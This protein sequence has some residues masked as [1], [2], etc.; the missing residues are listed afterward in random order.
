[1]GTAKQSGLPR[2]FGQQ[3]PAIGP[4]GRGL[5]GLAT[6]ASA[7]T[8]PRVVFVDHVARLS[9]AEIAL[10]RLVPALADRVD[11]HV[12]LGEDGPLV[13]R[14]RDAGASVE[15]LPMDGRLRDVRKETVRPGLAQV[16]SLARMLRYVLALRRRL[17]QVRP[18]LVHTNSLKAA[19]YGGIAGRL[20]GIPVIWHVRD[21]IADDY[22]PRS[23]VKAV[24]VLARFLPTAVIAN[25]AATLGT[26]PSVRQSAVLYNP[27]VPDI[28]VSAAARWG[29][30]EVKTRGLV[31]VVGRLAEW[32]GQHVF[33]EAFAKAFAAEPRARGRLIGSAMFGEEE[34]EGRLRALA[35]DLGIAER[36]EF[37]GF[38]ED[39]AAE[40]A[41][42]DILVH[43]SITPE[44]FG[45]V[46]IE[47]M[48]AGVPVIAAAAGGPAEIIL[49]GKDGLLTAPGDVEA[50]AEALQ[51]LAYDRDFR[52][53]LSKAALE[54]VKR[55]SPEAAASQLLGIYT[56]V[57]ARRDPWAL[58]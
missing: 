36:I 33:L 44:P 50:L 39:V 35:K 19:I 40:L 12:I 51:R 6:V 46:V 18:D 38:R 53:A 20:A 9:G 25:S 3:A 55:F 43:C 22:L 17:R 28:V 30:G 34:Y 24:R 45:Q 42:L 14:L 23:A 2:T 58:R 41:E 26:V 10:A 4:A 52:R 57:L 8:R 5:A 37:R 31:G 15:V 32:K 49:N 29:D 13:G 7:V 48:A 27:V 16:A 11:C 1:L 21:R 47:G 56:S 54:S